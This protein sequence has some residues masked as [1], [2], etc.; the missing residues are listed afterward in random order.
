MPLKDKVS[1]YS[2]L[3]SLDSVQ[4]VSVC[5]VVV[6]IS[7]RWPLH[8]TVPYPVYA[9]KAPKQAKVASEGGLGGTDTANVRS[10]KYS[11]DRMPT[12]KVPCLSPRPEVIHRNNIHTVH[13]RSWYVHTYMHTPKETKYPCNMQGK[14]PSRPSASFWHSRRSAAEFTIEHQQAIRKSGRVWDRALPTK[15]LGGSSRRGA[16]LRQVRVSSLGM[17]EVSQPKIFF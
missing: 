9:G 13:Y 14:K 12:V 2:V 15:T 5:L 1:I 4:R 7:S 16:V 6:G 10:T 17:Y 3:F 11:V 8:G